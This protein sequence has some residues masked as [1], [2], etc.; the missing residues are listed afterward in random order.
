MNQKLNSFFKFV[1]KIY[2]ID[3]RSEF[4]RNILVKMKEYWEEYMKI[5]LDKIN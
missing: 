2:V 4:L 5:N 1:K 3:F